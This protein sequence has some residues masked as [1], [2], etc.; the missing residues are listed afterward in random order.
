MFNLEIWNIVIMITCSDHQFVLIVCRGSA[1]ILRKIYL[2]YILWEKVLR[3]VK[4]YFPTSVRNHLGY[5]ILDLLRLVETCLQYRHPCFVLTC[6]DYLWASICMHQHCGW[7]ITTGWRERWYNPTSV[8]TFL[9][10]ADLVWMM[11]QQIKT[12][13]FFVRQ[14]TLVQNSNL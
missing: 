14:T 13:Y 9:I 8:L 12:I 3:G 10:Q 7:I 4:E 6:Y 1:S 11:P 5:C 2:K